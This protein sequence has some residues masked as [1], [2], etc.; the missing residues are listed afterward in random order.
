MADSAAP[1]I[2]Y[3]IR[4]ITAFL[5]HE[6]LKVNPET[7]SLQIEP[8]ASFLKACKEK[9]EEYGTRIIFIHF[10]PKHRH[11][12]LA[13]IQSLAG[14]EIQTLRIATR[15]LAQ[16]QDLSELS[17]L[18]IALETCCSS[19]GISF[20]SLG[21]T[22]TDAIF[23]APENE[24]WIPTLAASLAH[25]SFTVAW[26]PHW[27]L[28]QAKSLARQIFKMAELTE[29]SANF[30]FAVSFNCP[31]CIPFFPAAEAPPPT[32]NEGFSFALG[33]ENSSLLHKAF[34]I[35]AKKSAACEQLKEEEHDDDTQNDILNCV[36]EAL[37][38][39]LETEYAKVENIA[40]SLEK[41]QK[42]CTYVGIDTSIAPALEPPSIP[43]AFSLLNIASKFG[44]SGTLATTAAITAALKSVN[45]L[46]TGYQGLMLPVCEDQ[47]LAAAGEFNLQTLLHYS[48]VCGVGLDTVP[49]PGPGP[50][51]SPKD[52]Q[53]L[54]NRV[55]AVL[56]DVAAL[57]DRLNKKPLTARLLPVLGAV[58]GD[59]TCFNN[60]Y[61]IESTVMD[62]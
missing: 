42:G 60:P 44:S 5:S 58:A 9:Y 47:G 10:Q 36:D 32:S 17:A 11:L 21:S 37:R 28:K 22:S 45:V 2:A 12:F 23:A 50:L 15:A 48:A 3:R 31:P 55:A 34:E 35:A 57:S 19:H 52:R 26:Q 30:R 49:I 43:D 40:K 18:A 62:L 41:T 33:L 8:I 1:S 38:A 7:L 29:G 14:Y 4:T 13:F 54:V 25:T 51:T 59:R 24:N 56:L 46:R 61:L 39:V 20:I 53:L 6:I 27:G 16:S